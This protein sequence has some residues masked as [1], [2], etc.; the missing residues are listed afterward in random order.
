MSNQNEFLNLVSL[1]VVHGIKFF[2]GKDVRVCNKYIKKTSSPRS[3]FTT[4]LSLPHYHP[5]CYE[6]LAYLK[7]EKGHVYFEGEG[8]KVK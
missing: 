6:M 8:G 1:G 7:V 4:C 2:L 3:S 5:I